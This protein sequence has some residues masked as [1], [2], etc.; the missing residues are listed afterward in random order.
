MNLAKPFKITLLTLYPQLIE[1]FFNYGVV[2]RALKQN[3]WELNIINMRDFA[4]N[5]YKS[6]DDKPYGGGAGQIIIAD[7]VASAIEH[8]FKMGSSRN[9][10]YPTPRGQVFN[11]TMAKD[12]A[13]LDGLTFICGH[14]EGI[15]ERVIEH[16]SPKE[17]SVGDY[18]L[19]GGELASLN[20]IDSTLRFL[21]NVL[22]SQNS[23]LEESFEDNLLEYPQ[24][25][26]PRVW[27]DMHVPEI[28]LS[29]NHEK[30]KQWQLEQRISITKKNR[31]DLYN[32]YRQ[33]KD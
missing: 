12:L 8:S 31:L 27:K 3:L 22:Q 13:K 25:S 2:G 18:I 5:N 29:G 30:I 19:T 17:I 4:T 21:K 10:I 28:L 6:V 33:N 20:I 9:L 26:K 16:Y 32:K 24:Y 1:D 11:N 23:L 7:I 15:D 14:F